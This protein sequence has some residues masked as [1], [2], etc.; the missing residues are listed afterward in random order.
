M[1]VRIDRA[2]VFLI[3]SILVQFVA[4]WRSLLLE[5]DEPN[6]YNKT[7]RWFFCSIITLLISLAIAGLD[8]FILPSS[9]V[10]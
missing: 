5:D 8:N 6:E 3:V 10:A 7:L 9:D 4:L 2:A 1:D